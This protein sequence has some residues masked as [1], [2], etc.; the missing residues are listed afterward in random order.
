[1]DDAA[2]TLDPAAHSAAYRGVRERVM[3][4]VRVTAPATF[5]TIAPATPDWRARDLIAHMVGVA[6][7]VVNGNVAGAASDPWTAAQVEAR[8]ALP[9]ADLLA[10][11]DDTGKK[12][13]TF[14]VSLPTH[15]SGQLVADVVTH[16]HD[17]R[18]AIGRPGARD[19][20]ALT[21]GVAW[22]TA[23]LGRAYDGRDEPALRIV[24][25]GVETVAGSGAVQATVRASTFD[26]GRAI[27]GRR[28]LGEIAAFEWDPRP[29]PERLLVLEPFRARSVPLGE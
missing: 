28:T 8:A 14:V 22:I 15:I 29:Y 1:V 4:L 27:A 17:L 25:D 10:E 7:D 11:W 19:S 2:I 12:V 3:S 18:H 26:L 9:L 20:D 6:T 21:I 5:E 16:E 23:A 24:A 13:E